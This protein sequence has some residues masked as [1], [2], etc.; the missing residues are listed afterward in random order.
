MIPTSNFQL[1]TTKFIPGRTYIP[2]SG[3]VYDEEEV[4]NAVEAARDCWWTEGRW[5]KQFEKDFARLLGTKYAIL[6]NSGS[7]ANLLAM[8]SLTSG[9]LGEKHLKPGDEFITSPVAFPTTVNPGI[10]Y[11]LVPVFVDVKADT[12]NIDEDQVESA[13]TKKTRLIM[14]AHTLG[15]PFNLKRILQ[16]RKKYNLWLIE[17][18]C[19]ALGSTYGSRL[20]G[21]FGDIATF[22]FYPA[23]QITMGE[24][25]AITTNNPLLY[26][27]IRQFR[28]WGRDCW[29]GTGE[30]NACGKRFG[31]KMGKLPQG[32]D[33]KYIFS[34]IGYNLKTTDFQAAIG[35]AQ[36][37][38]LP[39]FIK[40]RKENYRTI[41]SFFSK[42]PEWF[43]LVKPSPEED[44][45][46]FGFPL[47]VKE[48]AP[49][50][51]NDIVNYLEKNKIGTRHIF[52][53]NLLRHPAYLNLR[54]RKIGA[55]T[56]ADAVMNHAFWLGVWPGIDKQKMNYIL[57]T[58]SNYFSKCTNKVSK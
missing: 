41:F 47:L 11:G 18:C 3:K 42:Y 20:V 50:G 29:C 43:E 48:N 7:S 4:N 16:I 26:R 22:S 25:G 49:F 10:Q 24:G 33:H 31:W 8:A 45:C 36:L 54:Y 58:L 53:G 51:R 27:T 35:V 30:D 38:K 15:K 40:R 39:E 19:D 13:I 2:A 52:A 14:L 46:W 56:H 6:T 37:K 44:P 34:Q 5:A 23:H 32:Y 55:L 12:L 57:K 28:D 21:T 9:S 17:D 1:P